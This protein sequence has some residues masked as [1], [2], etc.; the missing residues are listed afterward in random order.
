MPN[1]DRPIQHRTMLNE[2]GERSSGAGDI[3]SDLIEKR[4]E[5][6]AVSDGRKASETT[7]A[8][9]QKAEDELMG[10]RP[11]DEQGPEPAEAVRRAE[12][13]FATPG[14]R[15]PNEYENDDQIG[16]ELVEEGVQEAVHDDFVEA[17]K[18]TLA[19]EDLEKKESARKPR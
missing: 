5:E 9:Y 6:L 3:S 15:R 17:G 1:Q 8:D 7:D 16:A 4:A 14:T 10:T 13:A 19:D 11:T 2:V 12:N 18:E